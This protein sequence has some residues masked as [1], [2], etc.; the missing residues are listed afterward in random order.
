MITQKDITST[1]V[2][3][4]MR[5]SH[6]GLGGIGLPIIGS[7]MTELFNSKATAGT[8]GAYGQTFPHRHT[9]P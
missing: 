1:T 9:R 2:D 5:I 8:A 6:T 3:G 4:W 7:M